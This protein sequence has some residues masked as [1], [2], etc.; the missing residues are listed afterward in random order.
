VGTGERDCVEALG[1]AEL[2]PV[3]EIVDAEGLA[4]MAGAAGTAAEVEMEIGAVSWG[5]FGCA[6]LAEWR[7]PGTH[8]ESTRDRCR[9]VMGTA[10]KSECEPPG[11]DLH[12][13]RKRGRVRGKRTGL[14]ELPIKDL[15]AV[16]FWIIIKGNNK[17]TRLHRVLYYR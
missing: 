11:C 5:P 4:R 7:I 14:T 9:F 13:C 1:I 15:Q 12:V 16:A 2:V 6:D 10:H 8:A 3:A 17:R